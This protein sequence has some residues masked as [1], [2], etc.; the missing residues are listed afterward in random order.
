MSLTDP[1]ADMFTTL[2][3][4][5]HAG[6]PQVALK[7]S[8]LNEKVLGIFHQEGFVGPVTVVGEGLKKALVVQLKYLAPRVP[9]FSSLKRVSK[10]GRRVYRSHRELKPL[11]QGMGLSV[12]S[13]SKGVMTDA[14]AIAKGL[15]GE[16]LGEIW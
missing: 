9:A 6:H 13:T 10:P 2:R 1:I 3:N 12:I 11:R 14:W 4:A 8:K 15:G 5:A 7:P 16:V